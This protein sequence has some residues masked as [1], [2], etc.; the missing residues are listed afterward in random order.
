MKLKFSLPLSIRSL[1]LE[2]ELWRNGKILDNNGIREVTQN[3]YCSRQILNGQHPKWLLLYCLLL[4]I[5]LT[6][7][8]L[9][10]KTTFKFMKYVISISK[11]R[12]FEKDIFVY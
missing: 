4:Y 9:L 3:I 5:I 10:M 2:K 7:V 1:Q 12:P 11:T 8:Q 6:I